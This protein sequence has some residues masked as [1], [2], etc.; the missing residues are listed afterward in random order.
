MK[1]LIHFVLAVAFFAIPSGASAEH[2]QA[3]TMQYAPVCGAREVQCVRAPC[4][5]VYETFGNRCTLN[6]EHAQY[7]HDGECS[8]EETGPYN[9]QKPSVFV[10]PA[11][12]SAWFDGCNTCVRGE[13]GT[14][15]CTKKFC[16]QPTAGY[17][18]KSTDRKPVDTPTDATSTDDSYSWGGDEQAEESVNEV[19][20]FF[21]IFWRFFGSLF[22]F[23]F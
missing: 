12:C 21:G 7:I 4:Y 13:N 14:A 23:S 5:P 22:N 17:C 1:Y 20:N 18:T 3:C 11:T 9:P 6:A 8:P 2:I 19:Y 16:S 10:P 15:A